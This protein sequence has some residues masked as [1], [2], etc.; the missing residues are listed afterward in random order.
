MPLTLAQINAATPEDAAQWLDGLYE[1][2]PW[3]VQQALQSRPFQSLAQFKHCMARVVSKAAPA[4]Q[5]ALIRAH[6]ELAGKA[7]VSQTLTIE[8]SNEQNKAGLTQC[9]PAE[10]EKIQQLNAAYNAKF[11]FPFILAVRGPRGT[12]LPRQRII[13][14]F[15]ERLRN[16][17]DF[18]RAEC[19]RNIHRIAELRLNDKFGDTPSDGDQVWD[20][21]EKLAT[22]NRA[23]QIAT[24]RSAGF[25]DVQIDAAGHVCAR[26]LAE[27]PDAATLLIGGAESLDAAPLQLALSMVC[28][29]KQASQA[30]RWAFHLVVTSGAPVSQPTTGARQLGTIKLHAAPTP[31]LHEQDLP[32][33]V[34]SAN[35]NWQARWKTAFA[36]LGLP[37]YALPSPAMPVGMPSEVSVLCVRSQGE[38][39]NGLGCNND[40]LQLAVAAF[41]ALL[42][43]LD[44]DLGH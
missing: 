37:W 10:L 16:S 8:S 20:G 12:G 40:D 27:K 28:V 9:S 44:Q 33:G 36:T 43:Q 32:L 21:C 2:S 31:A 7:M 30:R 15:E 41:S 3:I 24:L 4:A 35:S 25:D 17:P 14:T 1:H 34:V 22:L 18:E 42:A 5:L 19:L 6:P 23:E 26:Y 38:R 39:A 11:G 29:Q 13:Q